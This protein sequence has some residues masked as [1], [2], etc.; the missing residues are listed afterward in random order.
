MLQR[1]YIIAV[2]LDCEVQ[3]SQFTENSADAIVVDQ[4]IDQE[5]VIFPVVIYCWTIGI[6]HPLTILWLLQPCV[7]LFVVAVKVVGRN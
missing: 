5:A 1:V 2:C 6:F 4:S 3:L 7:R